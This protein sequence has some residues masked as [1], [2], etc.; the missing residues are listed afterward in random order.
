[1]S[2]PVQTLLALGIVAV[3]AALLVWHFFFRKKQPGCGGQCDAISPEIRKLQARL[4]R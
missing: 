3:A 4:K 1:M 2:A